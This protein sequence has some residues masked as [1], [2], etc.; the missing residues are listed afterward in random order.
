V[1]RLLDVSVGTS[2]LVGLAVRVGVTARADSTKL[3]G[4]EG[5]TARGGS[6]AF[7]GLAVC[8]DGTASGVLENRSGVE[9]LGGLVDVE[10]LSADEL[11]A[12]S[13]DGVSVWVDGAGSGFVAL[14]A[15]CGDA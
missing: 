6:A 12:L 1:G 7:A 5:V 4:R 13:E 9:T 15:R 2:A 14:T 11:R 3:R 8:T 10:A